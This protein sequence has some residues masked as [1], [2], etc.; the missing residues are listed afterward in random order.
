MLRSRNTARMLTVLALLLAAL[1]QV[2][3]QASAANTPAGTTNGTISSD[4]SGRSVAATRPWTV[5]ELR[6]AKPYPIQQA[7]GSTVK[8]PAAQPDGPAGSIA[9]RA[10]LKPLAGGIAPMAS[11]EVGSYAAFP[12]SA[13]GK[14]FFRQ[15]GGSYVCSAAVIKRQ[16]IWTAGHCVHAGNNSSASWSTNVV[17]VPQYFDG[18]APLGQWAVPVLWTTWD[19][20][21]YGNPNGLDHDYAGGT[22]SGNLSASTG[23]LGFAYNQSYSQTYTAVGYP[24]ASPYDGGNMI[25]CTNPYRRSGIGSPATFSIVCPMTGGSSGGGWFATSNMVGPPGKDTRPY[26]MSRF[27]ETARPDRCPWSRGSP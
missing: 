5:A 10:P 2:A 7:R 19:W 26:S 3:G 22:I 17:F 24:A 4:A 20:Y 27:R 25:Y 12:Y 11:G 21:T 1:L 15:N 8:L 14:V 13:F 16:S 9:A 23:V 6:A 18:S